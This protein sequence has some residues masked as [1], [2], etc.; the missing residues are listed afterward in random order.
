MKNLYIGNIFL[1]LNF[2]LFVVVYG[3][4][5]DLRVEFLGEIK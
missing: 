3:N 2:Y 4:W 5:V 1:C